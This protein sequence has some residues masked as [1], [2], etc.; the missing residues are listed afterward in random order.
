MQ[1]F[2]IVMCWCC[3]RFVLEIAR[4]RG[5]F[6]TLESWSGSCSFFMGRSRDVVDRDWRFDVISFAY[7][8]LR[9][10]NSCCLFKMRVCWF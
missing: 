2:D 1:T 6:P 3:A 5:K 10:H 4:V 7:P 9:V 8:N